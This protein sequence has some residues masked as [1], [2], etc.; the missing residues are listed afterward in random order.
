MAAR[1]VSRERFRQ[2]LCNFFFWDTLSC[3]P[4]EETKLKKKEISIFFFRLLVF[5]FKE[6]NFFDGK[7]GGYIYFFFFTC[8]NYVMLKRNCSACNCT[9]LKC[10]W[11]NRRRK[12]QKQ[13][14]K[15]F[16]FNHLF[17]WWKFSK[18]SIDLCMQLMSFKKLFWSKIC[19]RT[20][21]TF[22]KPCNWRNY[23][24]IF[25][26]PPQKKSLETAKA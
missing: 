25:N 11:E 26:P 19:I 17:S 12:K 15:I 4:K 7:Q 8:D 10:H 6:F 23:N 16:T 3:Q 20:R 14:G 18:I 21:D 24:L 9:I 22:F 5:L 2:K 1:L 13:L